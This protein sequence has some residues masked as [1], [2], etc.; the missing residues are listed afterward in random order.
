MSCKQ[1]GTQTGNE[2]LPPPAACV[3]RN[4]GWRNVHSVR[5]RQAGSCTGAGPGRIRWLLHSAHLLA[6]EAT[7]DALR[8]AS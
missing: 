7:P 2:G 3:A 6:A 1:T 8:D 4:M 5:D